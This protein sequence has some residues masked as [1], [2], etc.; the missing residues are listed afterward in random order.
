MYREY[1]ELE[2]PRYTVLS[3]GDGLPEIT[4]LDYSDSFDAISSNITFPLSVEG[5]LVSNSDSYVIQLD[6]MT[7]Q[8][9]LFWPFN[10]SGFEDML[11]HRVRVGGFVVSIY[12]L[13][14]IITR[15]IMVDK[16]VDLGVPEAEEPTK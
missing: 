1:P 7:C 2:R 4:Y 5:I 9:C 14:G 3:S 13:G 6:G 12:E 11:G 15:D 8:A 16:M 10:G